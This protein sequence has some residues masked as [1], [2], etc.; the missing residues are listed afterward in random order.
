MICKIIMS[1]KRLEKAVPEPRVQ[2][3]ERRQRSK[4]DWTGKVM[5]RMSLKRFMMWKFKNFIYILHAAYTSVHIHV[6]TLVCVSVWRPMV[7]FGGPST[8]VP[9]WFLETGP[10]TS[11]TAPTG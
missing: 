2:G 11:L 8:A 5:T 10:L 3:T 4:I 6:C 7:N 1:H 9:L